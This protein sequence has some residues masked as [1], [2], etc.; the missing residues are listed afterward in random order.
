METFKKIEGYQISNFGRLKNI[1]LNRFLN[2][3]S[4]SN[5]TDLKQNGLNRTF[6]LTLTTE[7]PISQFCSAFCW[8]KF[9]AI[10]NGPTPASCCLFRSLSM[11]HC[12]F[13]FATRGQYIKGK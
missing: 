3:V 13:R 11:D 10:L 8:L 5:S 12:V 6:L 2:P 9:E 4:L 1:K 7:G